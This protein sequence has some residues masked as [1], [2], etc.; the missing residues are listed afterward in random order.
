MKY[1]YHQLATMIFIKDRCIY[2]SDTLDCLDFGGDPERNL[3]K[4]HTL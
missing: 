4:Y 3:P 2:G 1:P